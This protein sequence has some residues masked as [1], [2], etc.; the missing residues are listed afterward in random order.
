MRLRSYPVAFI[1]D[2]E[3]A[4]LMISV[5]PK[6]R[7]V[8]RFLWAKDPFSSSVILRFAFVIFGV[9]ASPF[10]LNA[11]INHHIE[12][13]KATHP[14][15]VQLLK[16]SINVNDVVCGADSEHEAYVLYTRSKE[17]LSHAC[18]NLRKFTTN[19]PSLQTC[20]ETAQKG[21]P[22]TDLNAKVSEADET[23]V[24]ATL[25]TSTIKHPHDQKVLGVCW[26]VSLD[27]L[28]FSLHAVLEESTAVEPTKRVVISLIGRI[29]DPL[30]FLSPVTVKFKILMQELCKSKLGWDQPLSGELLIKWTRLIDQLRDAPTISLPRCCL[31]GP[32]SESRTYR[33]H[34]FCDAEDENRV[35][36]LY[37]VKDSSVTPEANNYTS[38]GAPFC[39]VFGQADVKCF[40][41]PL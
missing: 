29:Y 24:Q 33:L 14:E 4:F 15:V 41:E 9:S 34:G 28:L 37:C 2:I 26:D 7:D 21:L 22:V 36:P 11:T 19:A 12:G 5:N 10:L 17:I 27:Q 8:L 13:Y 25:P 32:R 6:D 3:K 23:Y 38:P 18:F 31:Q 20:Q 1:A 16:Q 39:S 35:L 30:G 40:R